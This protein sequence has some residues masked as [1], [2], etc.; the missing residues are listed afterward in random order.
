M[1][2][3]NYLILRI[4]LV[5]SIAMLF[6]TVIYFFIQMEEIY[7]GNEEGLINLKQEFVVKANEIPNFVEEMEKTSPLNLIVE[8][9]SQTEAENI[10]ENFTTEQIYFATELEEEEVRMLHSAFYCSLNDK[11]YKIQFFTSTIESDDLIENMLYLILGLWLTL[12]SL[13]IIVSRTIIKNANKPFYSILEKLKAFRLDNDYKIEFPKTKIIEYQQLNNSVKKLIDTNI[14]IYTEQKHFIE[15]SS[16]ELQTPLAIIISRL[17]I[18]LEKYQNDKKLSEEIADL[19]NTLNRMKYLNSNL[20]L[21][22]K[23]KNRQF[24]NNKEVDLSLI[25]EKVLDEFTDIIEYK[26]ITLEKEGKIENYNFNFLINPDLAHILFTNL[27]KN[28]IAYSKN[29]GKIII[30]YTKKSISIANNGDTEI[31]NIFNRYFSTTHS[32]LG[33]SIVK[34]ISDLYELNIS[35]KYFKKMH[36]FEIK[37]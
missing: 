20:L 31:Q 21:L 28:A 8:E 36:I 18:L 25:L 5:F 3:I 2:L 37:L 32:G 10:I 33:L 34:S 29:N 23:V 22:S 13:L 12:I 26:Q 14:D 15:N 27:I 11:Y 16:H 6:W 4:T 35:Y 24:Q 9:I 17:E 19:L 7:D 30:S 1:K